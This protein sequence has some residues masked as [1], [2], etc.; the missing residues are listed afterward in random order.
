MKYLSCTGTEHIGNRRS[1]YG[2]G[3]GSLYLMKPRGPEPSKTTGPAFIYATTGRSV[4]RF[5]GGR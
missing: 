2:P 1:E 4:I 5:P 3:G